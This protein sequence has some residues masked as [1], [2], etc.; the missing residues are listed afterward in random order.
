M[1]SERDGAAHMQLTAKNLGE[2]IK[3]LKSSPRGTTEKRV[4]PRVGVRVKVELLLLDPQTGFGAGRVSAWVRDVSA[5]GVGLLANRPFK[6]GE[7]FDLLAEG[8]RDGEEERIACTIAYCRAVG[9]DVFR[10]G[11]KFA[12]LSLKDTED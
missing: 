7:A 6:T 4:E 3:S 8:D 10:V 5:T 12:K 9:T 2:L 1:G 11:A